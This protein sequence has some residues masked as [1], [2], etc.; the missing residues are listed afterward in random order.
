MRLCSAPHVGICVYVCIECVCVCMYS[1]YVNVCVTCSHDR[2]SE[3]L[4]PDHNSKPRAASNTCS[5]LHLLYIIF[6]ISSHSEPITAHGKLILAHFDVIKAP[7][8]VFDLY[9]YNR[10]LNVSP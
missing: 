6:D 7:A 3:Q 1:I 9:F 4:S 8:T 10:A 5:G 2:E